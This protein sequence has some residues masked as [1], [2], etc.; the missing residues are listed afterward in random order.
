M[1]KML[2]KQI[3][4]HFN[5]RY[6]DIINYLEYDNDKELHEQDVMLLLEYEPFFIDEINNIK[7]QLLLDKQE[8]EYQ[9]R[10]ND[11]V[12]PV[13]HML[14]YLQED[15]ILNNEELNRLQNIKAKTKSQINQKDKKI[16]RV[17]ARI[18][19]VEKSISKV[20]ELISEMQPE[21][22]K[23]GRPKKNKN[24]NAREEE[25]KA[26]KVVESTNAEKETKPVKRKPRKPKTSKENK[27]S[28]EEKQ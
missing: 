25:K 13:E 9:E 19:E 3:R 10:V 27:L 20:Q 6:N 8:A 21:K 26:E 15:L 11:K 24:N 2:M 23:V 5:K 22:R 18:K 28:E 17:N 16:S 7:Q 1:N 14:E 4:E 12:S